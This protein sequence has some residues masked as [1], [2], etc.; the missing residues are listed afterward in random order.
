MERRRA[1]FRKALFEEWWWTDAL[2][3]RYFLGF[4]PMSTENADLVRFRQF[5]VI[6]LMKKQD[7]PNQSVVQWFKPLTPDF[8]GA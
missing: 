8:R 7:Q 3:V 1:E 4:Y 2:L 6:D 5:Y